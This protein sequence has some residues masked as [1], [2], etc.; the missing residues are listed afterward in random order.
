MNKFLRST[1]CTLMYCIDAKLVFLLLLFPTNFVCSQTLLKQENGCINA[2]Y[3]TGL[4]DASIGNVGP[5]TAAH[6]FGRLAG[7][8]HSSSGLMKS[9][10]G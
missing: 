1:N 6:E 5:G 9:E 10:L 4:L 8:K 3:L 7:L 2:D